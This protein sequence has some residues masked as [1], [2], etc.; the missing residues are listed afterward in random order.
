VNPD[1]VP[2][3][4][5][6]P[7]AFDPDVGDVCGTIFEFSDEVDPPR[8]SLRCKRKSGLITPNLF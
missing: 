4:A 8:Y 3:A 7:C 6:A 5:R 1:I 2:N